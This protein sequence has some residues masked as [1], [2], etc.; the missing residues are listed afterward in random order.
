MIR[1][2]VLAGGC[3]FEHDVSLRSAIQVLKHLDRQRYAPWPVFLDRAG[4]WWVPRAALEAGQLPDA[5]FKVPGM[6]PLRPG[7]AIDTLLGDAAIDVVFPVLHGE[8]GEDGTVQGM[9][10]LHGVPFVGAGC[11]ASAVAMDKIRTRECLEFAGIPMARCWVPE[12]PLSRLEPRALAQG[13]AERVG[14][15]CFLKVDRSGSSI[16]VGRAMSPTDVATFLAENRSRGGRIVVEAQ[17]FG[18]EFTQ[19]VLGNAD[20][21]LEALPPVAI[22]PK[23]GDFFDLESKYADGGAE[24]VSPPP[25]W[26]QERI[27]VAQELGKRCHQALRCDGMSRTDMIWTTE[28]PVV[29]EVNTIPGLTEASL[30]PKAARAAGYTFGSLLDRLVGLAFA[31]T[32]R[33]GERPADGPVRGMGQ[34]T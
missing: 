13:I 1:V 34:A 3:S 30:L 12:L 18:A 29:L 2:A 16:G 33:P 25:G 32:P 24:E 10:E 27:C 23:R 26:S 19:P 28:G 7:A 22:F 4:K 14:F 15:P 21:A 8:G 5:G 20:G 31:R 11:A 17:A 9:L 6:R